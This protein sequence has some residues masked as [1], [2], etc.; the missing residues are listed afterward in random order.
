MPEQ[1]RPVYEAFQTLRAVRAPVDASVEI[2]GS[3]S[4]TNR[5]LPLAAMAEGESLLIKPLFSDD[6]E[7]MIE[8]LRQLGAR[9]AVDDDL[10]LGVTGVGGHPQT[11]AQPLFIGNSGTSVR[12]L[13]ALCTHLPSG[14]SCVLDGI[15]RMRQRPIQ[16]LIDAIA[17]LGGRI[18]SI[19]GTGC[20][21]IRVHG[22]GLDGGETTVSGAISSQYLSALMMTSPLA[23]RDVAIGIKGQLVSKP[24]VAMTAQ[25]MEAFG[26]RVSNDPSSGRIRIAAPTSYSAQEYLIEPDASNASYFLAAAAVTGGSVTV[27]ELSEESVQGDTQF[28]KV[29][30]QTGCR[31]EYGANYIRVDGPEALSPVDVDLE[32]MPDMAQ[33]LAVVCLFAGG[34]SRIRGLGN[35]RVKETDR[36]AAIATELRKLGASVEEGDDYWVIDPPKNPPAAAI[37]TYDDHRM[38]MA[39]AVAGLRID[40]LM[41]EDPGCVAKT[42][43]DFWDRWHNAFYGRTNDKRG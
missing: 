3:K 26:A 16:D 12:F 36:I 33:T 9:I 11:P 22:G 42:F 10:N 32:E 1:L 34:R 28:A 13:A 21:P 2:P 15:E 40:G 7:R 18:E 27:R 39:F 25:V 14:S 30:K 20:P 35:L 37:H 43:P 5:A 24:Y 38:A 31:V 23:R 29:L 17:P 4:I 19:K 8:S 6:T 41:I